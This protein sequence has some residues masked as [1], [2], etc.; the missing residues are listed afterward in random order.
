MLVHI[1]LSSIGKMGRPLVPS[2]HSCNLPPHVM[3]FDVWLGAARGV[4]DVKKILPQQSNLPLPPGYKPPVPPPR[5]PP[6]PP[7]RPQGGVS[8]AGA[9][10]GVPLSH[11]HHGPGTPINQGPFPGTGS[12]LIPGMGLGVQPLVGFMN[13][14]APAFLQ[15]MGDYRGNQPADFLNRQVSVD[16]SLMMLLHVLDS[17]LHV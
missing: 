17:L 4:P 3:R 5:P 1:G 16:C 12:Q 8:V 11:R 6:G 9:F 14:N 13:G 7:P 15:G 10:G 2:L